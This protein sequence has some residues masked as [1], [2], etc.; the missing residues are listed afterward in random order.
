MEHVQLGSGG[1]VVS[2]MGL[3]LMSMSGIYG[4]AQDED[5]ISP[6]SVKSSLAHTL[7]RLGTH[8][9]DLYQPARLDPKVPARAGR[10]RTL[11]RGLDARARQ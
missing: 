8:Y 4:P 5:S 9:A 11:R 7:T 10:W 3:G 6:N 1:P 2:R